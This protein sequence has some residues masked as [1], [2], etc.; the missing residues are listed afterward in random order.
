MKKTFNLLAISIALCIGLSSCSVKTFSTTELDSNYKLKMTSQ[1]EKNL[2][3][4]IKVF[5]S[6]EE[7]PKSFDVIS[8][9]RYQ[10]FVLPWP[11]GN[12]DKTV[13]KNLY[14]RAVKTADKQKGDAVIIVDETHF[15]II[16]FK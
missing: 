1:K 10:P 8:V 12:Y 14:Q 3:A 6:E 9:N 15:K 16:K 7:V 11:F 13:K 2:A 4:K 5:A